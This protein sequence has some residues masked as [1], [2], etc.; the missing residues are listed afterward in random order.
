MAVS[1]NQGD[2]Q[3]FDYNNFDKKHATLL[4]PREWVEVLKYSPDNQY[5]AAGSHDDCVYIWK[6]SYD[7]KYSLH[8]HVQYVH[9]SAITAIDWTRDSRFL[10]AI[11]QAYQKQ[12]YDVVEQALVKDGATTLT[13]PAIWETH[14]CKLGWDVQGVFPPG[15]DGTDVNN[16]DVN[17]NRS[18]VAVGD[19]FG[20]LCVYR[21]PCMKQSQDCRR[22]GGHSEHVVRVKFSA[23]D[24]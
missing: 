10:R 8:Y 18:L 21:Y 5:L 4:A 23:A 3:I 19:D 7:G 6:I 20:S 24:S 12:Y 16:V 1:N 11:D 2:I 22:I 13:D 14:T 15:A 17:A 9:S